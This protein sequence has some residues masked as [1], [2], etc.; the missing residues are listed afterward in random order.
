MYCGVNNPHHHHLPTLVKCV[1]GGVCQRLGHNTRVKIVETD[2]LIGR[3]PV[4]CALNLIKCTLILRC[5]DKYGQ[6]K[7][8][9]SLLM[10]EALYTLSMLGDVI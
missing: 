9:Y 3:L 4:D 2:I 1:G 10:S 5:R 7:Q 8:F 6:H